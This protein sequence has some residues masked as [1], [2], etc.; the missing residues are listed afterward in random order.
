[1]CFSIRP[2]SQGVTARE[3]PADRNLRCV[4]GAG[5]PQPAEHGCCFHLG[6]AGVRSRNDFHFSKLATASRHFSVHCSGLGFEQRLSS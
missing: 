5:Q 6:G 3:L 2:S 1:M 4:P